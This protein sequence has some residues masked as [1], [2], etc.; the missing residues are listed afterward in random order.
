MIDKNKNVRTTPTRTYYKR[1]RPLPYVIQIVGRPGTGSLP[2]TIAPP[3]HPSE[4][5]HQSTVLAVGAGSRSRS[6]VH[7]TTLEEKAEEMAEK[8]LK[9]S[10]GL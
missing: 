8:I 6:S 9:I 7:S 10:N 4:L 2:S 5:G 1:S 3:D